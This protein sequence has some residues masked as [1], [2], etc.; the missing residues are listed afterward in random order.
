[1]AILAIM[2]LLR[3]ET[4]RAE[5]PVSIELVLA[6]DISRSVD[7]AEYDLQMTGIAS[8]FRNP[9]II[10]LIGQQ[11][12][13]AVTLFQW[14]EE[15]DKQRI[16]PWQLLGD[17]ATVLSFANEVEA[18]ERS[19]IRKFTSIGTAIE[20]GVRLIT[21][22]AFAGRQLKIDISGDGRDNVGSLPSAARQQARSL[23]IAINGLPILIDTYKLDRYY[24]DKVIAGPGAFLEIANDYNDFAR[25]FLR[26]LR[27][28]ITPSI[29]W[30][31][32]APHPPVQQADTSL[33]SAGQR[34]PLRAALTVTSILAAAAQGFDALGDARQVATIPMSWAVEQDVD[35]ATGDRICLVVSR[36]RDVT[37]RLAQEN[38]A[39][40]AVWTVIVGH[41]NSPASLRYLRIGKLYYTSD[42]P[43]FHGR[44]AKE[45]VERLRSPGEFAF[46]WAQRPNHAKRGG[47]FGTGNFAAKAAV[48]ESWIR[49]TR[50]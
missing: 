6:V 41:D 40:T 49:G 21:G 9:E 46:E 28:E 1:M 30:N 12:G 11:N 20:F 43:S 7:D 25:A 32:A 15:V 45:I 36:G 48:C 3:T 39:R 47:L 34:A 26:K 35:S 31:D 4:A 23:G 24:R 42:Q 27:R 38:G 33:R 8:A 29:S 17:P 50:I 18:L 22:N 10:D 37:A 14:S 19:P 13:V 44:E 5:I 16:I 2:T